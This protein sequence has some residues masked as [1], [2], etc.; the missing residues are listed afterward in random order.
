[1]KEASA[2]SRLRNFSWLSEV[3]MICQFSANAWL[4]VMPVTR[5]SRAAM[6]PPEVKI[7]T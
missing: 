2:T 4:G 3:L 1:M 6:V 7:A 5:W